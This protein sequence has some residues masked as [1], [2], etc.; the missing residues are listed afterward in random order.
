MSSLGSLA[1]AR[2][3]LS[4]HKYTKKIHEYKFEFA[5]SPC[6][7]STLAHTDTASRAIF[8]DFERQGPSFTHHDCVQ[9]ST[10]RARRQ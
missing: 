6:T 10:S 9:Q 4:R 1:I 5:L 7:Q 8:S 3:S 2:A